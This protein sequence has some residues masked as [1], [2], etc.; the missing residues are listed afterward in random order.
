MPYS[1]YSLPCTEVLASSPG[2]PRLLLAA[3]DSKK[4]AFKSEAAIKSLGRLGD[5]ATEVH[6]HTLAVA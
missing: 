4:A 6:P 2:L 1:S 3:S 5:E